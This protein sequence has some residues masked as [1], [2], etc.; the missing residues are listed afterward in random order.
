MEAKQRLQRFIVMNGQKILE[1]QE[2]S[3]W[4]CQNIE[5]A[6]NI[7]PGIYYIY[8]AEPA[9]K[10]KNNDGMI[11]HANDE[12]FYQQVSGSKIVK[13]ERSSF[14]DNLPEV[15]ENQRI[16]YDARGSAKAFP[17]KISKR[18]SR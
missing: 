6:G 16:V 15:G 7:K 14:F 3:V 4:K 13:H 2:K 1:E 17:A 9:N 10:A 12:F 11:L 8:N 18:R 5:N